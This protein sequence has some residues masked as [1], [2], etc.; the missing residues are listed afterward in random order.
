MKLWSVPLLSGLFSGSSIC[1]SR[2]NWRPRSA[3]EHYAGPE[4]NLD[5]R[6]IHV[7][8]G[9]ILGG[10]ASVVDTDPITGQG[11]CPADYDAWEDACD[12]E[13]WGFQKFRRHLV[14]A[15]AFVPA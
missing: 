12:D 5:G 10:S 8:A 14:R 15:D 13:G 11:F 3:F 6:R 2:Y 7:A 9:K 4:K 1:G